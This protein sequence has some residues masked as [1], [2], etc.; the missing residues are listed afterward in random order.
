MKKNIAFQLKFKLEFMILLAIIS[1]IN[2]RKIDEIEQKN[3]ILIPFKSYF[4]KYDY[5]NNYNKAL[6]K[7]KINNKYIFSFIFVENK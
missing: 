5:D 1:F 7:F 6:T 2:L 3:F 4:S